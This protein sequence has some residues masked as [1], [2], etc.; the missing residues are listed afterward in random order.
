MRGEVIGGTGQEER[1]NERGRQ[2]WLL[3]H[4]I[5]E[6]TDQRTELGAAGRAERQGRWLLT[7]AF[8]WLQQVLTGAASH[9]PCSRRLHP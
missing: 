6:P 8:L 9:Q 4:P 5:N 1:T 2:C 7:G 3:P